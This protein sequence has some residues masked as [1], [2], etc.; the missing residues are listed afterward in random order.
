[1]IFWNSTRRGGKAPCLDYYPPTT[2]M[3]TTTHGRCHL[4]SHSDFYPSSRR[5]DFSRPASPPCLFVAFL[6]QARQSAHKATFPLSIAVSSLA[7]SIRSLS[8]ANQ[9][10]LLPEEGSLYYA[11]ALSKRAETREIMI[12]S[13]RQRSSR[14]LLSQLTRESSRS[15][16]RRGNLFSKIRARSSRPPS[17]G[18]SWNILTPCRTI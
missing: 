5:K 3:K 18:E 4:S 12:V 8:D 15:V 6:F 1:M 7:L 2:T 11:F 13:R 9:I 14:V 10:N 16:F 17:T